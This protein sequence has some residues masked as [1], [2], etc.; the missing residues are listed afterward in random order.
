M[1]V[2]AGEELHKIDGFAPDLLEAMRAAEVMGD[3]ALRRLRPGRCLRPPETRE[4]SRE[5]GSWPVRESRALRVLVW[6][7]SAALGCAGWTERLL[8]LLAKVPPN[9]AAAVREWSV[10]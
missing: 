8:S 9:K 5:A 4:E 7:E 6:W 2:T 1:E 3:V 10:F